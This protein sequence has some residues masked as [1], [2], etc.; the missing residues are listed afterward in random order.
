M[1]QARQMVPPSGLFMQNAQ[2]ESQLIATCIRMANMASR[3]SMLR[4]I[5][6]MYRIIN[7]PDIKAAIE[8]RYRSKSNKRH[9]TDQTI[10]Y[11]PIYNSSLFIIYST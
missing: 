6:R 11:L 2:F 10:L 7:I 1:E 5:V 3:F 4:W 8:I 9:I